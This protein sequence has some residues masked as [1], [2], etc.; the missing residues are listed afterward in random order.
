MI[1]ENC[2]KV[3]NVTWQYF[4]DTTRWRSF[5]G[6]TRSKSSA[7]KELYIWHNA[8]TMDPDYGYFNKKIIILQLRFL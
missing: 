6:S 1:Y 3:A 4:A 8:V 2:S 5:T 7:T